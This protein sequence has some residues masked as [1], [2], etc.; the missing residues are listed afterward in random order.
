MSHQVP[1]TV[2]VQ[3]PPGRGGIAVLWLSGPRAGEILDRA[4]RPL[5]AHAH[6]GDEALR[7]GHLVDG[8]RVI[9]EAVVARRG[10][11]A[12]I[13]IHGGPAVAT[14][15]LHLL[16][17]LGAEVL[18][19]PA[20]APESFPTAHPN[21]GNPTIGRELL[22]ALPR[23]R[24]PR[25]VAALSRQWSAG[26]S[27]L[28]RQ[29]LDGP[30]AAEPAPLRAAAGRLAAMQRAIQPAEVVLAGPPN[31]GKSTLANALVGRQVSLVHDAAGTTRDWVRELALLDGLPVWVTDTAGLWE[32][33]D[34]ASIDA[35][36]VRRARRRIQRADLVLLLGAGEPSE[37][38]AWLARDPGGVLHVAT[39][40]DVA[41][42]FAGAD[43][44]VCA[45]TGAGLDA[46]AQRVLAA[47][48]LADFDPAAP[49]AFTRR[50]ADLLLRAAGALDS[51]RA[52]LA[53]AALRE[54]LAGP[55]R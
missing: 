49:A 25:V 19:A 8:R 45:L 17:R 14:A 35:E 13:S 7:L 50:Q 52:D 41:P 40:T 44:G 1:T 27:E 53:R 26:L 23:A 30:A 31:A 15:V 42:P 3:T 32:T 10:E 16:R 29:V 55:G 11:S 2:A 34:P 39:Q 18:P 9:D 6:A 51:A 37:A 38:P 46:L 54:L 4:F 43:A 48:G 33:P 20:A 36:A 47:L 12:E 24:S 5:R 28:A 21:G 22:E